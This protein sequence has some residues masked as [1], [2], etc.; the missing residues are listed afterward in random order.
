MF[1]SR[2]D[3][4]RATSLDEALEVL[5]QRGN[6]AKVLAGGQSLIPLMKLRFAAPALI[7]DVN[8]IPGLDNLAETADELRIGALVRHGDLEDSELLRR[9]YPA[10]ADAAPLIADPIVRNLGTMGGS[11]AHADPAGDWGS[12][13]LALGATVTAASSSGSRTIPVSDLFRGPFTTS[14][15][16][17]ELLT[18]IRIPRAAIRSG[19]SYLKM[20]RKVGDFA[21]VGVAVQLELD[22]GTIARA[23]IGLTA[24]GPKNIEPTEAEEVLT[25]STPSP[26]VFEEVARLAAEAAA[27]VSDT[28]GSADYKRAVVRTFVKRGLEIANQRAS[29]A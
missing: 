17:T 24:A 26:D 22:D 9:G 18:E 19:G 10:L 13:M 8:R 16:P 28:R 12:V 21:T 15:K 25:G 6:E 2:F 7:V 11:L 27:P 4:T 23:G 1:P 14:L 20:E 3:Y 5:A 29:S